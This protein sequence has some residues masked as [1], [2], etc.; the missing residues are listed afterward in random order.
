[1]FEIYG[2]VFLVPGGAGTMASVWLSAYKA[3]C[4]PASFSYFSLSLSTVSRKA[5]EK[6]GTGKKEQNR[7]LIWSVLIRT[8]SFWVSIMQAE[9]NEK[10]EMFSVLC[11]CLC[12]RVCVCV[13]ISLSLLVNRTLIALALSDFQSKEK[14]QSSTTKEFSFLQC[15]ITLCN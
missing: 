4:V 8:P 13:C 6:V 5:K 2:S 7:Q 10:W 3:A 14:I 9:N 15:V 1:M 11:W 12:L